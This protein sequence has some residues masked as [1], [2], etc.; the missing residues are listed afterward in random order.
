MLFDVSDHFRF[1]SNCFQLF[2][3]ASGCFLF[4]VVLCRSNVVFVI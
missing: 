2:L 3:I 4:S 1:F